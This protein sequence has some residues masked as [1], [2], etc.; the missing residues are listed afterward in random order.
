MIKRSI[1]YNISKGLDGYEEIFNAVY[2]HLKEKYGNSGY[3]RLL[4]KESEELLKEKRNKTIEIL[5][6]KS[7]FI[8]FFDMLYNNY[9]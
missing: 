2:S 4:L 6:N 8:K 7:K 9:I 1:S 3:S 5:N